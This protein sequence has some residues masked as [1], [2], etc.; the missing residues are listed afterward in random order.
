MIGVRVG[1]E[2]THGTV[3]SSFTSV[4]AAFSSKPAGGNRVPDEGRNGQDI[5]FTSLR[6]VR[7]D[8][9]EVGDSFVYH[10]TV[11]LWLLSALG[12]VSKQEVEVG[13]VF[14]NEFK[15]ADD[16]FSLS[17]E[18]TQPRR[19]TQGFQALNANVDKLTIS[20]DATGDLTYSLSG[21]A[22]Y[23]T[24]IGVPTFSFSS[25]RPFSAWAGEV[26]LNGSASFADLV[27]GSITISRN[28]KPWHSIANSQDLQKVSIGTRMVEFELVVDF[29]SLDEFN[30]WKNN[31]A[32]DLLIKWVD[33]DVT[34]GSGSNPEFEV[35]LGDIRFEEIEDDVEPDL[36]QLKLKGK[37]VYAPSDAST[38]VIRVRSTKDYTA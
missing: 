7:H 25:A 4:P 5:H 2:T 38:A 9:F 15:M 14:D 19:A 31:A 24:E 20:F 23:R 6:T 22:K 29:D 13:V 26:T 30:D 27:K 21:V 16:P 10:D 35:K 37:A 18:W 8:A 32:G 28:R 17:L 12:A 1:K 11:G 36:P 3:A 34:L 33:A